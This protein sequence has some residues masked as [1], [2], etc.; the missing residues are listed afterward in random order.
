MWWVLVRVNGREEVGFLL[1]DDLY[2]YP[3]GIV[4]KDV[5][6]DDLVVDWELVVFNGFGVFV[7]VDEGSV[8]EMIGTWG[9]VGGTVG[10]GEM[11]LVMT[12]KMAFCGDL[13]RIADFVLGFEKRE[14]RFKDF[15]IQLIHFST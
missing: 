3:I 7:E 13:G 8:I 12:S 10:V 6:S 15:N 5:E 11:Y 9:E 1:G 14:L 4:G 2:I